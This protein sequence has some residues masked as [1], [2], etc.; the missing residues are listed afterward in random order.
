MLA[1]VGLAVVAA[2][3]FALWRLTRARGA[4]PRRLR[5]ASALRI[6]AGVVA[7]LSH[8]ALAFVD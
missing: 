3:A 1:W 4:G 7:A 6:G 2:T 8:A 5:L